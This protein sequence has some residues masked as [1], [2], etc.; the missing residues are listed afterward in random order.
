MKIAMIG[1][2]RIPS[3]EGG[4]EI[5]V[6]ETA[7]RLVALGHIVHAYNRM[8][9]YVHGGSYVNSKINYYRGIKIIRIPTIPLK[10]LDALIYSFF[11]AMRALFGQYDIVHFHAEGSGVMILLMHLFGIKTFS[12][13]HGLDW[14]RAKWGSLAVRYIK[15]GEKIIAKYADEIIALSKNNQKYFLD[16]Y[17]RKVN[18]IPNGINKPIFLEAST[19]KEKYGLEKNSYVLFLARLVPEKG[20]DYLIE[21]FRQINTDK[22]LVIAGGSSHSSDYESHVKELAAL[23][24]RIIMTGFVHGTILEELFSNCAV[25]VLPSDVEGMPI[26]LLEAMSYGCSCLVSDI[27]ENLEVIE[28]FAVTFKK[29]NINDLKIKLENLLL[30]SNIKYTSQEIA[31]YITMR[32]NWDSIINE[33]IKLYNCNFEESLS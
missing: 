30:H 27:P 20:L 8:G 7:A 6:E 21:A 4:V 25:Y 33:H 12:T 17:G 3:R 10:G 13:I 26:S 11:A 32:Y 31:S 2:K 14:Q 19:I 1:H 5:V 22:K 9:N 16:N 24:K 29:A 18:F 15:L 28:D 23:D